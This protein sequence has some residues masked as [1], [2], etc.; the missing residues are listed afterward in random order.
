M[1]RVGRREGMQKEKEDV[2]KMCLETHGRVKQRN[3]TLL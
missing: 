1:G 3:G 2:R